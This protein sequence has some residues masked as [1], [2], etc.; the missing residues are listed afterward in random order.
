MRGFGGFGMGWWLW[1][2]RRGL[3]CCDLM[4]GELRRRRI[5]YVAC[6]YDVIMLEYCTY[7]L[8]YDILDAYHQDWS[9]SP[10][11]QRRYIMRRIAND[12]TIV[13]NLVTRYI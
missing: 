9:I 3:S 12:T 10:I 4:G 11:A 2:W 1:L 7:G 6:L 5:F 8:L 13:M